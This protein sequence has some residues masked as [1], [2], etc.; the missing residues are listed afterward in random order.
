MLHRSDICWIFYFFHY[1]SS[2]EKESRNVF[3]RVVC[4]VCFDKLTQNIRKVDLKETRKKLGRNSD[5]SNRL[6]MWMISKLVIHFRSKICLFC[7]EKANFNKPL[8][9]EHKNVF[10]DNIFPLF[11]D[12][13]Q[14]L[15]SGSCG[16]C[17]S[18]LF[19][20]RFSPKSRRFKLNFF[21][22]SRMFC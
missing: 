8:Y 13:E 17:R 9:K 5:V 22:Y 15:P 10:S 1:Y 4:C 20:Y 18:G 2:T 16:S 14:F 21:L 12:Y 19:L 6:L 7:F 11:E 3:M